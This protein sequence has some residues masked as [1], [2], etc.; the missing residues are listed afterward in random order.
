MPDPVPPCQ[1]GSNA[2]ECAED[3]PEPCDLY[4]ALPNC[5]PSEDP[6][7]RGRVTLMLAE[8]CGA[9]HGPAL[10][11]QQAQ[12]GINFITDLDALVDAGYLR[13]CAAEQSPVVNVLRAKHGFTNGLV[14]V[15]E[16]DIDFIVAEF[17]RDCSA[18]RRL[19]VEQPELQGCA[20]VQAERVLDLRC[21]MCHGQAQRERESITGVNAFSFLEIDSMPDMI[22]S[23]LVIPCSSAGSPLVQR[24]R[25][26]SMPPSGSGQLGPRRSDQALVTSFIDGLCG[27]PEAPEIA[28]EYARLEAVLSS[29]CADCHHS[30]ALDVGF[31]GSFTFAEDIPGLEREGWLIP[32]NSGGSQ[33]I[34]AMR[35]GSMPPPSSTEPRPSTADIDALA[36]LVDRPCAA[37]AV[38]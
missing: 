31:I 36:A 20:A 29:S 24:M 25:D 23:G 28:A 38:P 13:E 16:A 17:D 3:P 9:C 15:P 21:G 37:P 8:W 14:D 4:P 22:R 33:L 10:T 32:C 2:P 1:P 6:Y 30:S 5:P 27:A 11:V 34:R 12:A 19:C 18:T 7:G 26:G 35:S